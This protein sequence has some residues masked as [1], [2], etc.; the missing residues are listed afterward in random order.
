VIDN[1]GK[2]SAERDESELDIHIYSLKVTRC[3]TTAPVRF[4]S[5]P[6]ILS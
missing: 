4:L 3:P 1:D 6:L 5:W 2:D